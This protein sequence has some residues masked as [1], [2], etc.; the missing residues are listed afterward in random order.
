MEQPAE[1]NRRKTGAAAA[2]VGQKDNSLRRPETYRNGIDSV[3]RG[4]P[5]CFSR[6]QSYSLQ[7]KKKTRIKYG[8]LNIKATARVPSSLFSSSSADSPGNFGATEL[9][10]NKS[11][12]FRFLIRR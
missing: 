6:R 11:G 4:I 2:A 9:W 5:G 7:K 12:R 8:V 3:D 10:R 1:G